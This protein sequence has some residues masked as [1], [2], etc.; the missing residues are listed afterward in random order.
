MVFLPATATSWT[1]RVWPGS[2][3]TAGPAGKPRGLAPGFLAIELQR[4]VGLEKMVVRADLD[5]AV[6]GVGDRQRHGLAAGIELDL[7]VLDEEFAGDHSVLLVIPGLVQR[8]P[9]ISINNLWIP[10]SPFGRP[11]MTNSSLP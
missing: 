10:G 11:G 9:G 8:E 6:A 5:R 4:R 1:S 2:K 3:R 7:A